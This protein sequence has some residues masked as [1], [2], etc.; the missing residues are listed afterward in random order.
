MFVSSAA[1]NKR[2]LAALG[3]MNGLAQTIVSTLRALGPAAATSLFAFSL[4]NNIWG[5]QF[6]YAVLL[7]LAGVGLYVAL[8]LPRNTWKVSLSL[9]H[10]ECAC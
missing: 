5:G 9:Y 10:G 7:D 1:P 2:S 6:A 3:A 4:L 8:Q